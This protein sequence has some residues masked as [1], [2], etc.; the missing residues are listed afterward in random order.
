MMAGGYC[1]GVL[2]PL[3]SIWTPCFRSESKGVTE[4]KYNHPSFPSL[5]SMSLYLSQMFLLLVVDSEEGTVMSF[6]QSF[7][8]MEVDCLL[9]TDKLIVKRIRVWNFERISRIAF[10]LRWLVWVLLLQMSRI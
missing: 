10:F 7:N 9:Q 1:Q 6:A 5:C 8:T 4:Q 2:S 3:I